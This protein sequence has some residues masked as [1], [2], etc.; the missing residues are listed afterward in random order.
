M[1]ED[2][3]ENFDLSKIHSKLEHD[4]FVEAVVIKDR[5][6]IL[7]TNQHIVQLKV[8]YSMLNLKSSKAYHIVSKE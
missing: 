7:V 8:K 4:K 5:H 2:T 1:R 3:L 6:I